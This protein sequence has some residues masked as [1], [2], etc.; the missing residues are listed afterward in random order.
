MWKL[1]SSLELIKKLFIKNEYNYKNIKTMS[2]TMSEVKQK[3][4]QWKKGDD[5][6]KVVTVESNDGK[7]T[8]FTDG[9]KIFNNVL[10]EFLEE[11]INGVIPFPAVTAPIPKAAIKVPEIKAVEEVSDVSPLH[12]LIDKLSKK[13]IAL[14]DTTINL[15]IPNTAV[16]NML[17]ENAD[18]NREDLIKTIAAVAV[19]QIEINKLQEYLTEEIT[20][21]VNNYYNE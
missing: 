4:Y 17:I 16:F 3:Q 21:F 9:S 19:S 13:N 5:F 18:E 15:N 6:G 11:V 1:K 8:T 20:K 2:E 10:T 7:F 12:A 14:F